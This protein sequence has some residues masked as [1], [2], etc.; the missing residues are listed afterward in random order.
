MRH[1]A[2]LLLTAVAM[3]AVAVTG[4]S[5]PPGGATTAPQ[6]AGEGGEIT[7]AMTEFAFAPG[8]VATTSGTVTFHLVND[9]AAPHQFA[10]SRLG[11]DH[12]QHLVDTGELGPGER[13]SVSFELAPGTYEIACHVPG[14]FEAGMVTTL[15]V[16]G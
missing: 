10:L 4:C 12:D 3:G 14:H 8:P 11:E 5:T 9:G 16:V 15:T 6:A 2:A 1:R 13:R 7:I